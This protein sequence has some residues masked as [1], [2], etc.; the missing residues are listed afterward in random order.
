MR[1]VRGSSAREVAE[2]LHQHPEVVRELAELALDD[3]ELGPRPRRNSGGTLGIGHEER[4]RVRAP[5]RLRVRRGLD[6]QVDAPRHRRPSPRAGSAGGSARCPASGGRRPTPGPRPRSRCSPRCRS[7]TRA[8]PPRRPSR[9]G[10]RPRSRNHV[11][12]HAG[13]HGAPTVKG[14]YGRRRG[15]GVGDR[16]AEHVVRRDLVER[17]GRG[18]RGRGRRTGTAPGGRGCR[19]R[20]SD[21][22]R[23]IL[24]P[25]VDSGLR[26]AGSGWTRS[27]P[28][29]PPP[30]GTG[31]PRSAT[32]HYLATAAG[33]RGARHGRQRR[34]RDRRRQPRARSRRARTCAATAATSSRSCGTASST[35]TSVRAGR[36]PHRRPTAVR[37]ATTGPNVPAA[38]PVARARPE[39]AGSRAALGDRP[40][41]RRGVVHAPR[42][43]GH[44]QLRRPRDRGDPA[45]AR[46]LRDHADRAAR[47][48]PAASSIFGG[49]PAWRAVYGG[50]EAGDVLRQP[51]LA[52]LIE[53]L[54]ADGPDAYYRGAVAESIAA[55]VQTE[56]GFLATDDLAAHAGEWCTPAARRV[57]RRR[58]RGAAS[59]DAGRD[60]ARGPAHPR[61]LRPR[62]P[63]PG[64]AHA[65]DGRGDEAVALL[66]RDEHV[67]D[68]DHMPRSGAVAPR[69]R[70]RS[71][72]TAPRST[73]ARAPDARAGVTHR[74]GTAYLCATDGD[75]L[76][77]SLIQSNFFA[78]GSGLHVPD[79]GIN[80]HN[81][82]ASFSL[83]AGVGQRHRARASARC[84][85]SSPRWS[86]ATVHRGSCS[87]A[88][89]ATRRR[90][91]TRRCSAAG[92]TTGLDLQAAI[93]RP[94]WRL[95]PG[96]WSLHVERRADAALRRGSRRP[97][98]R[99]AHGVAV[100]QRHG[101]RARDR[102]H[103][104][105]LRGGGRPPQRGRVDRDLT[106]RDPGGTRQALDP[107]HGLGSRRWPP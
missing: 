70:R 14:S 92:S 36:R 41:G 23:Q 105:R 82:G 64:R 26:L 45:G 21:P 61:R 90:R 46:R 50:L 102:A 99:R 47:C 53:L 62:R 81:R 88:W 22:A 93:H 84:T 94:R 56:G 1:A 15:L 96:D 5:R 35:A 12:D 43:L 33:V 4:P 63:R 40:A 67:S 8:R 86:C 57:P 59:A 2:Q 66:D 11:V 32:P 54:A 60:R 97:R 72:R 95:E 37:D 52:R 78:F 6:V 75:G 104:Q 89:A 34:R 68:P 42:A 13:P 29:S 74:G 71:T 101:P 3:D 31:A 69:R 19:R 39:G 51:A 65:P 49:F 100:R 24:A 85:P 107:R 44:P 106:G 27:R 20:R 76:L 28:A 77:V 16:L 38:V 30:P 58:G 55:T 17:R 73:R 91:S 80:L 83:D 103:R 10:T 79:W 18:P 25:M 7:R 87:A 98:S 48:S 9:P